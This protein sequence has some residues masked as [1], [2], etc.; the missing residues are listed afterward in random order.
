MN[1]KQPQLPDKL[2]A[3]TYAQIAAVIYPLTRK[4]KRVDLPNAILQLQADWRKRL[5]SLSRCMQ[6]P[7]SDYARNCPWPIA[8]N[9]AKTHTCNERICPFCYARKVG[10]RYTRLLRTLQTLRDVKIIA[11]RTEVVEDEPISEAAFYLR[12]DALQAEY[13]PILARQ[14]DLR[15]R[16]LEHLQSVR[17]AKAAIYDFQLVPEHGRPARE[18]II[19]GFDDDPFDEHG[20]YKEWD[21][22]PIDYIPATY[23][24][25]RHRHGFVA[26]VPKDYER[27]SDQVREYPA[28]PGS[29]SIA[30]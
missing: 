4:R 15:T 12:G 20:N 2:Y 21:E 28:G 23:G 25:W 6:I 26:I 16:L 24:R 22:R 19:E 8:T 7:D 5:V 11:W 10:R 3:R 29:A 13:A 18:V 30:L 27:P 9:P 14:Q 1:I 17:K